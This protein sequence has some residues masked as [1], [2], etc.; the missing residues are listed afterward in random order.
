MSR[1]SD[2]QFRYLPTTLIKRSWFHV[3]PLSVSGIG[4]AICSDIAPHGGVAQGGLLIPV[5]CVKDAEVRVREQVGEER[6]AGNGRDG[7]PKIDMTQ[8]WNDFAQTHRIVQPVS[9]TS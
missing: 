6:I 7:T 3:Y 9:Q 8:R 5:S 4:L 2:Y 1:Q